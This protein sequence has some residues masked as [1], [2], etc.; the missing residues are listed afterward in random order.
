MEPWI[1]TPDDEP[2]IRQPYIVI[3]IVPR[4]GCCRNFEAIRDLSQKYRIIFI[5]HK[6]DYDA[7]GQRYGEYYQVKDIMD[8]VNLIKHSSLYVG[9]QTLYTW[10]A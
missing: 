3:S 10:L 1:V 7:F 4:Y 6:H 2:L 5:G 8:A 9:T